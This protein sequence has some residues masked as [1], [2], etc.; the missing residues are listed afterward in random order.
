MTVRKYLKGDVER[1]Y[2]RTKEPER[3]V[4]DQ[5]HRSQL[6]L[7]FESDLKRAVRE[8]RS[9]HGLYEQLV[10]EGYEGS[11]TTVQGYIRGLRRSVEGAS[12]SKA[13]VPLEFTTAA[14]VTLW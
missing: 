8:R 4:L 14:S 12:S 11:Y 5:C 7:W 9:A 6:L 3:R 10:L 2:R 13:F 1:C